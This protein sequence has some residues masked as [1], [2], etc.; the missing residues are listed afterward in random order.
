MRLTKK[1]FLGLS[2]AKWT[3]EGSV[4]LNSVGLWL[5]LQ[6]ANERWNICKFDGQVTI[7]IRFGLEYTGLQ[8]LNE[9]WNISEVNI[10]V[11]VGI[12]FQH[13]YHRTDADA[14]RSRKI[15]G[16]AIDINIIKEEVIASHT[17]SIVGVAK[18]HVD[19]VSITVDTIIKRITT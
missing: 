6:N 2:A 1:T 16:V 7:T 17:A 18:Q 9:C 8:D 19:D 12:S 11:L 4:E 5:S 13:E 14:G 3:K 10:S 15:D